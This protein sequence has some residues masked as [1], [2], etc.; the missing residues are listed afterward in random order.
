MDKKT[1]AAAPPIRYSALVLAVCPLFARF[2]RH[3]A[4]SVGS[5]PSSLSRSTTPTY[6]KLSRSVLIFQGDTWQRGIATTHGRHGVQLYSENY[7]A[8]SD[9]FAVP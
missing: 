5:G 3:G 8:A 2:P 4:S 9:G 6:I 7:Y 1:F